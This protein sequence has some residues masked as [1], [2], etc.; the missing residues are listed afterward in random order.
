MSI[1]QN[2]RFN[3]TKYRKAYGI[4]QAEFAKKIGVKSSTVSSWERGANSP[5]IETLFIICKFFEVTIADMF[6]GDSLANKEELIIYGF[7]K[8]LIHSY[9][10]ADELDKTI[11][12]KILK[13]DNNT[14]TKDKINA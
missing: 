14:F 3:I 6:G 8:D 7:E 1:R 10:N 2:I 13:L 11:V 9:R 4:S 12:K 5:D